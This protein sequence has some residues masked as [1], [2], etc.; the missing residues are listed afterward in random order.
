M[1]ALRG[2]PHVVDADDIA[3]AAFRRA[4][5]AEKPDDVAVVGVEELARCGA[6]DPDGVD[7]S[8]IVADVLDV[9]QDVA[10]PV[11]GRRSSPG[12][13]PIPACS[14]RRSS[15]GPIPG[16]EAL[17]EDEPL[18]VEKVVSQHT[19]N[20]GEFVQGEVGFGDPRERYPAR[21]ECI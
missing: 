2:V 7:L 13:Y 5:N 20:L 10:T 12:A 15:A 9:A 4:V 6:V 14:L 18:A 11:A 8:W 17:E 21:D 16:R 3:L 1:F 19:K